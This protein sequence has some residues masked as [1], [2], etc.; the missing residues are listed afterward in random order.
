M[1]LAGSP[2]CRRVSGNLHLNQH[3]QELLMHVVQEPHSAYSTLAG[4][5]EVG[6]DKITQGKE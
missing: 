6:V 3:P 5:K 1:S 4:F 2:A